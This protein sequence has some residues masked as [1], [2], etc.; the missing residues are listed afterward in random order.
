MVDSVVFKPEDTPPEKPAEQV[1]LER[2]AEE[3]K[4][5]TRPAWLPTNFDKVEDYNKAFVEQRA[6]ITR[7]QQERA[8]NNKTGEV[9]KPK[10]G[11]KPPEGEKPK[12][13]EKPAEGDP[14]KAAKEALEKSG[15]DAA[16]YQEEFNQTGNVSEENRAKLAKSLE[17]TLGPDARKY[18]DAF[19]EGQQARSANF[20]SEVFAAVGGEEAYGEMITWAT[21]NLNDSEKELFNDAVMKSGDINKAKM[22]VAGLQAKFTKAGGKSPNLLGGKLPST[23]T[24][25]FESS[26]AMQ[27]AMR[28]PRYGKDPVY[29]KEV[30]QRT[31]KSNF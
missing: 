31:M 13:G 14:E 23:G 30:E 16:P 24:Q 1:R 15:V 2:I 29:T 5:G 28:D 22:A 26:Y 11:E 17:A 25:G 19:I 3:V 20:S 7:L 10:E 21:S 9:E 12:E 4:A 6:E 27:Q 18:V 8:A